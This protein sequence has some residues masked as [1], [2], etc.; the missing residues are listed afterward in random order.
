MKKVLLSVVLASAS[1]SSFAAYGP[2]GCGLGTEVVFQNADEWHEHVL[3]ATTNGTS[4]NQTFGMTSGT[5]GCDVP[6]APLAGGVA[7][8]INDNLE[9]LA[10]DSAKGEGETLNALADLIGVESQDK[11][12]FQREMQANFDVIF[13]SSQ[14]TSQTA[15]E[16]IVGVMAKSPELSKYLG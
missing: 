7:L 9:P 11:A 13:A 6:D 4:G 10:V 1:F 3:A 16:D 14:V 2:A 12:V 15:Y 8:F 5:L